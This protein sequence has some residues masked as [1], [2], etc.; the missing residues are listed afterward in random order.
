MWFHVI[1][2]KL[3]LW[4][5]KML[6]LYLLGHNCLHLTFEPYLSSKT[7]SRKYEK[8][9]N[10]VIHAWKKYYWKSI[11]VENVWPAN[12]ALFIYVSTHCVETVKWLDYNR[13]SQLTRWCSGNASA[14]G[15]RGPGF[16]PRLRQG[17]LCLNFVLL[18]LCFYFF[19]QKLIIYYKSLQFIL[20]C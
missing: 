3:S 2:G 11:F 5:L 17:F 6:C 12:L 14:L 1:Y 19:V 13:Y 15:A 16:N 10:I 20:Q 4:H 18:L 8:L 9:T 7:Y